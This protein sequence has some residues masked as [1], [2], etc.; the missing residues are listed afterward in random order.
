MPLTAGLTPFYLALKPTIAVPKARREYKE[1]GFFVP[2][3][4][5]TKLVSAAKKP[6]LWAVVLIMVDLHLTWRGHN[7]ALNGNN[8]VSKGHNLALNELHLAFGEDN[9][10]P[11]ANNLASG[12]DDLGPGGG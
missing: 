2:E 6:L 9:L 8:L 7:P 5:R 12:E 1:P 3:I 4:L 10:A 11:V